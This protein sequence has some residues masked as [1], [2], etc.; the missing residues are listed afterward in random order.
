[1]SMN[2]G[3]SLPRLNTLGMGGRMIRT[4]SGTDMRYEMNSHMMGEAA[5]AAAEEE[6]EEEGGKQPYP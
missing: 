5:A 3:G 4:D 6:E 2:G 1:M